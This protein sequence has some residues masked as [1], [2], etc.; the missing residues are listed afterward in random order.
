MTKHIYIV[1]ILC[2]VASHDILAQEKLPLSDAE[3][4][5]LILGRWRLELCGSQIGLRETHHYLTNR[6]FTAFASLGYGRNVYLLGCEGKW[7]VDDGYLWRE[8]TGSNHTGYFPVGDKTR[9]RIVKLDASSL[10]HQDEDGV[11][12]TEGRVASEKETN[13]QVAEAGGQRPK[14]RWFS[15]PTRACAACGCRLS[16]SLLP[17]ADHREGPAMDV[18]LGE[19]ERSGHTRLHYYEGYRPVAW[20]VSRLSVYVCAH[21]RYA[22]AGGVPEA[23]YQRLSIAE[24][25]QAATPSIDTR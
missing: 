20:G 22:G 13:G 3:L 7:S 14:T 12:W 6:R 1:F 18:P 25:K 19:G 9:H 4:E 17:Y 10:R 15:D 8:I 16:S 24:Q 5:R 21:C 2:A 11:V 23:G